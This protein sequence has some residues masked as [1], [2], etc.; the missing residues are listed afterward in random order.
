MAAGRKFGTVIHER[1]CKECGETNIENFNKGRKILCKK[2][3][4]L[5]DNSA[6]KEYAR[7]YSRE[8]N[9]NNKEKVSEKGKIY[10]KNH[11]LN[12]KF[13]QAKT[14]SKTRNLE[15]NITLDYL[16]KILKEQNNKCA[17]TNLEFDNNDPMK[18]LSIDRINSSAG[19][20]GGNVQ[21][22]LSYINIMKNQYSEKDFIEMCRLVY[23]NSI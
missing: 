1:K 3:Q 2:H 8:Y 22:V 18:S 23:L 21:L 11:T 16:S 17:Y 13:I 20:I 5:R 12:H 6:R 10:R 4:A 15:F 7:K 19:Y 9:K 14:R